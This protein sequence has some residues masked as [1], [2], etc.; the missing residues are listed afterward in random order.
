MRCANC[1]REE[2]SVKLRDLPI[3]MFRCD[4]CTE[5]EEASLEFRLNTDPAESER[6][7]DR[8][9]EI[10][11]KIETLVREARRRTAGE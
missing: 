10:S 8:I 4:V 11:W 5:F 1:L 7:Y 6:L 9:G 2:R 3:G